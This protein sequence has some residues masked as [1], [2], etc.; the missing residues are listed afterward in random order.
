MLACARIGAIHS[1]VFGGFAAKELATRID[2]AKPKV[3]PLGELRPR[4]GPHRRLQ[5]AARRGDRARAAQAR[6]LPDPATA[7]GASRAHRRPRP[8]LGGCAT[9][10]SSMPARRSIACRSPPPIRSTFSTPRAR[11]AG[12]RAWCATMA[13]TWS[14]SN[15][16]CKISTASSP[17]RC[18]GRP[19]TSAGWSATATSSMRRCSTAAP[20][21]STR[22]SRSARPMPAR[23]GA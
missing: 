13:A 20:R 17:A 6:G 15:G 19:P 8:R 11:P 5:A 9:M 12:R 22:A 23:S 21:S 4:A 7:A 18:G 1:V 16:R 14:R 3:D 2:D 10:R